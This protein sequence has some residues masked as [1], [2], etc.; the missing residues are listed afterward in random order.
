MFIN[1]SSEDEYFSIFFYLLL[2]G[3]NKQKL[4]QQKLNIEVAAQWRL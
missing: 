1:D 4:Y 3:P 2:V